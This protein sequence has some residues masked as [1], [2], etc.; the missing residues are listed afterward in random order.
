P[1]SPD[2]LS[3]STLSEYKALS[4][5]DQTTIWRQATEFWRTVKE[6]LKTGDCKSESDSDIRRTA[7]LINEI[8][9]YDNIVVER[10]MSHRGVYEVES[11]TE[12]PSGEH[13]SLLFLFSNN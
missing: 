2:L 12:M 1:A 6:R 7:L 9:E 5:E 13:G 4:W 3:V 8:K 11:A 10:L